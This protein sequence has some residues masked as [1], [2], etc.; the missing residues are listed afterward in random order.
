MRKNVGLILKVRKVLYRRRKAAMAWC[1]RIAKGLHRRVSP[2]YWERHHE[3]ALVDL[4]QTH[5]FPAGETGNDFSGRHIEA[6]VGYR[7]K[8]GFPQAVYRNKTIRLGSQICESVFIDGS[9]VGVVYAANNATEK[10]VL[11]YP[12]NGANIALPSRRTVMCIWLDGQSNSIGSGA[13]KERR[14]QALSDQSGAAWMMTHF[15]GKSDLRLTLKMTLRNSQTGLTADKITGLEPL[16]EIG[17]GYGG[18]TMHSSF[19]DELHKTCS[20]HEAAPVTLHIVAGTGGASAQNIEPGTDSFARKTNQARAARRLIE[21]RGGH[22]AV[23]AVFDFHGESDTTRYS[24][25]DQ[26]NRTGYY[27]LLESRHAA[28]AGLFQREFEQE[29]APLLFMAQTGHSISGAQVTSSCAMFDFMRMHPDKG[30]VAFPTYPIMAQH[31]S[32]LVHITAAGQVIAGE[33][34]E[35]AFA[36]RI[37]RRNNT[38]KP[39]HIAGVKVFDARTLDV[40]IGGDFTAPIVID[41]EMVAA[42]RGKGF[43]IVID[44]STRPIEV[45]DV[46]VTSPNTIRLTTTVDIPTSGYT[47]RGLL[48]ASQGPDSPNLRSIHTLSAGNVRDSAAR[49]SRIPTWTHHNWLCCAHISF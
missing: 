40:L 7:D 49:P 41:E 9:R 48:Y 15:S 42:R 44:D 34:Y 21:S 5:S 37:L 45:V 24:Q 29:S 6:A 38:W 2:K 28:F 18:Q 23:P 12:A 47:H 35:H 27:A 11:Y 17:A 22:I 13:T 10:E 16:Q 39:M 46:T 32:D 26:A 25:V 31:T 33:L 30:C 14:Y 43:C 8:A 19:V 1:T 4:I 36:N 3:K 20:D